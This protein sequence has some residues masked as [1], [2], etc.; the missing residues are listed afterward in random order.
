MTLWLMLPDA[1]ER[2]EA[3]MRERVAQDDL[4]DAVHASAPMRMGRGKVATISVKGPL[5]NERSR[6]LDYFG[7]EYTTY[8][9]IRS[10]ITEA[11]S[12]GARRIDFDINSPGGIVDGIHGTMAAIREAPVKTRA[13]AGPTMASAAYMLASQTG[14]IV[15]ENDLSIIGSVGV[16]TSQASIFKTHTV[17]NTDSPKKDNDLSTPE[18]KAN[19]R[20]QLDDI[21]QVLA[22]N[23]A[24]GRKVSTETVKNEYGQGA[25]MT[26]RKA[27]QLKMIDAIGVNKPT[28]KPAAN[29]GDKMDA[30]TLKEEHRETYDAIYEAGRKAER[31]QACAHL[32]LAEG[33]GDIEAAH[34]AIRE[35]TG[36]T[37]LIT[38]THYSAAMKRGMR[39][40]RQEDDPPEI[41]AGKSTTGDDAETDAKAKAAYE[42]AHSGIEVE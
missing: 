26:A 14:E 21:F 16:K 12:K 30:K 18:G 3:I 35:G 7:S 33:S 25:V 27:L 28:A 22:E 20:E 5:L 13:I 29:Q 31:E 42:A 34:K 40:E 1:V 8:G 4:D 2:I 11:V 19:A 32:V 24:I 9:D 15:A 17:T 36:I 23:I 37:P 6:M 39:Q 10:Q 41:G 38:S